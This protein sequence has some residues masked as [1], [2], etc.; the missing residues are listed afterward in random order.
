MILKSLGVVI[1]IEGLCMVPPLIVSFVYGQDDAAAF[2]ISIILCAVIGFSLYT[3]HIKNI[4][5]YARDGFVMVAL[6]WVFI[7]LLGSIPFILSNTISSPIDAFFETVSGFTTTG[8]TILQEIESLPKGIL[9]WRSFTQWIGGMGV[10]VLTLAVLPSVGASS[11]HIIKA[12]STGP[13]VEKLVPKIGQSARILYTIYTVMTTIQVILLLFAGMPLYDSLIHAFGTAG[14]GGFSSRNLS[15]GAYGNVYVEVVITVFTILFGVNFSLYYQILKGNIKSAIEDEEFRF[16]IGTITISIIFVAINLYSNGLFSFSDSIRHSSFQVGT[17]ITT[18]GYSTTDFNLWPTFSKMILITLMFFGGSAGSTAGGI[19][20]L[21]I[22]LLLKTVKRGVT[23]ALH[24]RAVHTIKLNKKVVDDN[25]IS[26]T[27]T[28]F[29]AYM[30]IFLVSLL[31]ITLNGKDLITSATAVLS[32]LSNVGP[33]FE[34]IGPMGNFSDFSHGSKLVLCFNM[35]A[36]RLELLP[37]LL[38]FSPTAWKKASI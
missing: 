2:I 23:K 37:M 15:V 13:N 11:L 19:K 28:F 29:F 26:R 9:F 33:G 16:Y 25:T 12:E 4:N 5:F 32:T 35:I 17:I 18:T 34:V 20:F 7:S 30:L 10:L 31:L 38:L 22:V 36:G 27:L 24:P 1:L 8:S 3:I 6:G 14:T 21:R